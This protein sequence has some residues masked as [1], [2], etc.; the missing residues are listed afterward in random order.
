MFDH[1]VSVSFI[2]FFHAK[3]IYARVVVFSFLFVALYIL[4]FVLFFIFLYCSVC[5][6]VYVCMSVFFS[7][8][9]YELCTVSWLAAR[10]V[11]GI[12]TERIGSIV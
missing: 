7:S 2:E 12:G 6:S 9:S 1:T 4:P 11:G 8:F 5:V 3:M 10:S